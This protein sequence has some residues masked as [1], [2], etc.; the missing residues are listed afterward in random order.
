MTVLAGQATVLLDLLTSL[1][2]DEIRG[3]SYAPSKWTINRH[4]RALCGEYGLERFLVD[5]STK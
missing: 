4:L 3:V 2:D 5:H 1:R